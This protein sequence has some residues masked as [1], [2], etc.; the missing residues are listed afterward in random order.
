MGSPYPQHAGAVDY[1]RPLEHSQ[2]SDMIRGLAGPSARRKLNDCRRLHRPKEQIM[3][4]HWYS[5]HDIST[6]TNKCPCTNTG[7]LDRAWIK[8]VFTYDDAYVVVPA[9][10]AVSARGT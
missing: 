6:S 3:P 5:A 2:P 10:S 1:H 4:S 7:T 8:G 9:C